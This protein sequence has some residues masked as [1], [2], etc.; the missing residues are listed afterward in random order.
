MLSAT[1]LIKLQNTDAIAREIKKLDEITFEKVEK[2]LPKLL[3]E[4]KL[5]LDS[6][7]YVP[8]DP[9]TIEAR[10]I[11]RYLVYEHLDSKHP[12]SIWAFAL[13]FRQKTSIH[14]HKYQGTV[15]VLSGP[16]TEK[17]YLPTEEGRAKLVGRSDR[18]RFHTNSDDLKSG[19][20]HQLKRRKEL[21]E[22]TS[23]TLHI[24]NM[25]AH[26]ITPAGASSDNRNLSSIYTKENIL[27]KR[28]LPAY[29]KEEARDTLYSAS[30]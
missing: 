24:Y 21:G 16:V 14:D 26:L 30:L 17:R 2:L 9:S 3:V 11:G 13:G 10:G 1:E 8:A 27:D 12:F 4:G 19:V 7:V 18:Y 5:V 25:P 28:S 6:S 22:G 23:V 20:V 15:T 29:Q